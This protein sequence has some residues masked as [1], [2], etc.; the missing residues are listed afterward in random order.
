VLRNL[1]SNRADRLL[2]RH[3]HLGTL[4]PSGG[5]HPLTQSG[6]SPEASGGAT[7][8]RNKDGARPCR[9]R[10]RPRLG[11]SGGGDAGTA[12]RGG[13]GGGGSKSPDRDRRS[14]AARQAIKQK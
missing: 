6:C 14:D 1:Q 5:V 10:R 12:R 13:A 3:R 4:M 11:A 9:P 2:P 8:G 7:G